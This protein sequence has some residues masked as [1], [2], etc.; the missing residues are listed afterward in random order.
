M[1]V[2]R[3][4]AITYRPSP[5]LRDRLR[6]YAERKRWPLTVAITALI[7]D[8]LDAYDTAEHERN[9][10]ECDHTQHGPLRCASRTSR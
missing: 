1:S 7:E 8:G 10:P 4:P 6:D 2:N 3:N 9:H 5:E